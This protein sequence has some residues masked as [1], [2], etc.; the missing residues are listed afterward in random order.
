[1]ETTFI[2]ALIDPRYNIIRYIGKSNDPYS[3]TFGNSKG[4]SHML[5]A[6]NTN[7]KTHKLDWLRN[8]IKNNLKPILEI[9]D[10]VPKSEW[11]HWE[12]WWIACEKEKI[13][14]LG[15]PKLTNTTS[16]GEWGY[17]REMAKKAWATRR[18]NNGGKWYHTDETKK[19]IGLKNKGRVVALENKKALKDARIRCLNDKDWKIK[20]SKIQSIAMNK[21]IQKNREW[22]DKYKIERDLAE[23]Y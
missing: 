6:N 22:Y 16:G 4:L 5:E 2:Y 14:V 18:K 13:K 7:R 1:M 10:E 9:L 21:M 17:N 19:K 20:R 23:T 8:L 11:Q 12:K 15:L 3:R